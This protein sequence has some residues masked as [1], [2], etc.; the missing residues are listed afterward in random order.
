[1]L[2]RADTNLTISLR[3]TSC[4][5]TPPLRAQAS[6]AQRHAQGSAC[7]WG[8]ATAHDYPLHTPTRCAT[9]PAAALRLPAHS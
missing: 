4:R 5:D 9:L 8:R 3:V 7:V 6:G 1:L 2:P